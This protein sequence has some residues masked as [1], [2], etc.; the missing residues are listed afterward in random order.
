MRGT[1]PFAGVELLR[2]SLSVPQELHVS[3]GRVY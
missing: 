2:N 3:G 1:A